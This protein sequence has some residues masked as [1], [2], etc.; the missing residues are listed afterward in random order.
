MLTRMGLNFR[1]LLTVLILFT[2]G[3][4]D[5]HDWLMFR[6]TEGNGVTANRIQPPLA[7]KWQILLQE[8]ETKALSF[9]PPIVV[10]DV[11]FF[12]SED[13]NF[14]ALDLKS[15]YMRWIF[16]SRAPVNSVPFADNKNLY[17]GSNDGHVYAVDLNTGEQRWSFETGYT[18]QSLILRHKDFLVFTSDRGNT[19]FVSASN[20]KE[21]HRIPNPV[22]S[23]HT[24]R[25]F[26]GIMYW[27]PGP[28]N[29]GA[30]F[31]A[32]DIMK[33]QYLWIKSTDPGLNWY[34]FPALNNDAI[35]YSAAGY[36]R[37]R[38]ENIDLV[39][40]SVDRATG[41]EIWTTKEQSFLGNSIKHNFK[42]NQL[43]KEN[44]HSLDYLAPVL[45]RNLVIY[46][47][48]DAVIR[49]FDHRNG[50]QVW[51]H[52]FQFPTSSAAIIA[53]DH[54]YFGVRGDDLPG[55]KPA[56]L[57]AL[58]AKNGRKLWEME[59]KGAILSA[60]VVAGKYLIF[61]TDLNYFYVMEEVF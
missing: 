56:R 54:V 23:H 9:N 18:V 58:S 50:Q 59:T 31:G 21:L 19:H 10:S 7:I 36:G 52:T 8:S 4:E 5:R 53:G 2:M 40:Y 15:G 46:N 22:W 57:V 48:G 13:G 27:A 32:Y 6:G 3:C 11:V 26:E 16:K 55:G 37:N 12:G 38:K 14:Y 39:Y 51:R 43:F 60:P 29:Y 33:K 41:E 42:S 30:S 34:S 35:F 20:G 49:A 17:F 47:S 28:R 45:W 1:F 61:G 25:V 44:L 24:F